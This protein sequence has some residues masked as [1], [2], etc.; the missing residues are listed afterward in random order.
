MSTTSPLHTPLAK[1]TIAVL[2]AAFNGTPWLTEQVNS[3]LSQAD[4]ELTLY[5][6]V[7]QS[8]DGTEALVD[9]LATT[10][11]RITVL[12]YGE[13]FG[14]AGANFFRLFKTVNLS[15]YEFV[16][17]SDQDDIWNAN[18]LSK[19]IAALK[20]HDADGYSSSVTAFWPDG[21]MQFINRAYDQVKWDYLFESA[22][23]G[24]SYVLTR[25]LALDF[26]SFLNTHTHEIQQVEMHDWLLYA[27][28]RTRQHP[29]FIDSESSLQYRQH[30]TNQFG[31]S[32]GFSAFVIRAKKVLN[33]WGFDQSLHIAKAIGLADNPFVATWSKG[34][35]I[36]YLQLGLH[37]LQCRRRPKDKV[38]FL[39]ACI[40]L[41]LLPPH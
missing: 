27:F 13:R 21:Q 2:L 25:S 37:C 38:L 1:P 41:F 20:S 17:L 7:D 16:A 28:S 31:A 36:G 26:Q 19:A 14:G 15:Q 29:W 32:V 4:V 9:Q 30:A 24:C 40:S 18:K 5:I 10:D 33:G 8:S 12:P 39:F 22:G 11:A 34:S 35:R 6:S 3:I 23:Q